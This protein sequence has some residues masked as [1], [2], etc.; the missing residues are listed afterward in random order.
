[1]VAD[2]GHQLDAVGQL[3]EVV[4]GATGEGF[5]LGDRLFLAREHDQRYVFQLGVRTEVAHQIQAIDI[6]HHQVLED[7]RSA[8]FEGVGNGFGGVLAI[9]EMNVALGREHAPHG[10]A[11][12]G[13]VVDQ[14]N[15]NRI[16]FH[17]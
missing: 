7:N 15:L 5:R 14:Q 3:H 6:G 1:M 2:A 4:V 11:H 10:L 9:V 13:L 12:H 8:G 17:L 16:V